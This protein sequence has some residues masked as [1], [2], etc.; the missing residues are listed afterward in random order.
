MI[1][2][3]WLVPFSGYLN[4]H[5]DHCCCWRIWTPAATSALVFPRQTKLR[6]IP[7]VERPACTSA[8]KCHCKAA[9]RL[10]LPWRL[11]LCFSIYFWVLKYV[12]MQ[13][14]KYVDVLAA[15]PRMGLGSNAMV[16]RTRQRHQC[17]YVLRDLIPLFDSRLSPRRLRN[18]LWWHLR[19]FGLAGDVP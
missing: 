10:V 19:S 8:K 3:N 11:Y 15:Q 5:S 12:E 4:L 6:S 17:Q 14:A 18:A 16:Q 9:V 13:N 2:I 1:N 7:V